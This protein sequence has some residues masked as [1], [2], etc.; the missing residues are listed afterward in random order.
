M[1]TSKMRCNRCEYLNYDFICHCYEPDDPP[2][3]GL[4]GRERVDPDGEQA[5]LNHRG[6]CGYHAKGQ[7]AVQLDLFDI[8]T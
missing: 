7:T 2:F 6:G 4:H 5:D 1:T 8:V 3:C